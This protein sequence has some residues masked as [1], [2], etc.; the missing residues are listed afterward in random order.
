MREKEKHKGK[1]LDNLKKCGGRDQRERDS[2]KDHR[3]SMEKGKK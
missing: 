3:E 2:K 1:L